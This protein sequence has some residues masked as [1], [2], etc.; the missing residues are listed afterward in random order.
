M[1]YS[2]II[3]KRLVKCIDWYLV[4]HPETGNKIPYF[5]HSCQK[6]IKNQTCNGCK[7]AVN[8]WCQ[9]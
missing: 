2:D 4:I 8:G 3:I 1:K 7:F 6:A 5:D 9:K